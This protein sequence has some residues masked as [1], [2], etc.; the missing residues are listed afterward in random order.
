MFGLGDDLA[1]APF[2]GI[3]AAREEISDAPARLHRQ[4]PDFLGL[5][6]HRLNWIARQLHYVTKCS[7]RLLEVG[8]ALRE[9]HGRE[10]AAMRQ[11][12]AAAEYRASCARGALPSPTQPRRPPSPYEEP[13]HHRLPDEYDILY[14]VGK[15]SIAFM[16][17]KKPVS[18]CPDDLAA[19]GVMRLGL[20]AL[21]SLARPMHGRPP[22]LD[23][24]C[25]GEDS[26]LA[27]IFTE[28]ANEVEKELHALAVRRSKKVN[29]DTCRWA[30][31]ASQAIAHRVT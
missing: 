8:T 20:S 6:G 4:T 7:G 29:R 31:A 27:E 3:G 12:A 11:A 13:V 28:R 18:S 16:R 2:R 24:W 19:L 22:L 14:R 25:R 9:S 17:E 26:G 1:R 5:V 30:R 21:A 15:R 23:R 10:G